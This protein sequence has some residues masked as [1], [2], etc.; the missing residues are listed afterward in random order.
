MVLHLKLMEYEVADSI[1]ICVGVID[2]VQL[3]CQFI[4]SRVEGCFSGR[5]QPKNTLI[6]SG[7]LNSSDN[8]AGEFA[9]PD[10]RESADDY[11]MMLAECFPHI[12]QRNR[13]AFREVSSGLWRLLWYQDWIVDYIT[14]S[15]YKFPART[16]TRTQHT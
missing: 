7:S 8:L 5:R 16:C 13:L 10:A 14:V 2:K 15:L 12:I 6:R 3:P 4:N 9:L 11:P 1:D